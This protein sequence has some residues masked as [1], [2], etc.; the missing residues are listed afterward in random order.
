MTNAGTSRM[1]EDIMDY[2]RTPDTKI[3]RSL[4]LAHG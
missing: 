3:I 2:T 1:D 4:E